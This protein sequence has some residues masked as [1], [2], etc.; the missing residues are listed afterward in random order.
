VQSSGWVAKVVRPRLGSS[1]ASVHLG[2]SAAGSV[3]VASSPLKTTAARPVD[4]RVHRRIVHQNGPEACVRSRQRVHTFEAARARAGVACTHL[5][6]APPRATAASE[7]PLTKNGLRADLH[8]GEFTL[9]GDDIEGL[10][11]SIGARVVSLAGPNEALVSSTVKNL[12]AGS[13]L[14]FEDRG[15]HALKGVPEEWRLFAVGV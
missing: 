11:V 9:G 10:A 8:T 7:V 1:L 3:A 14:A 12:V 13:G 15:T 5:R 4:N 2:G 6:S